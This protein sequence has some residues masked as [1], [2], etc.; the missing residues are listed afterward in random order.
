M[1]VMTI[2]I[3]KN[4]NEQDNYRAHKKVHWIFE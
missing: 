3:N 2:K 1:L 4:G